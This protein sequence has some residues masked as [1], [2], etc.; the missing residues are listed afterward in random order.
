MSTPPPARRRKDAREKAAA[1]ERAATD[2]VLKHGY[3]AVKVD[4]ICERA[5]VSQRT[6]FNHFGTKDAALLGREYP[7]L[8]EIL[9]EEFVASTGPLMAGAARL[10]RV[11]PGDLGAD[12]AFLARRIRAIGSSPTLMALQMDRIESLDAAL[13]QVIHRR[14]TAQYPEEDAAEL[15]AQAGLITQLVAGLMRYI[16]LSWA[17]EA[18]AGAIPSIDPESISA[19]LSRALAKLD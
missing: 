17:E 19:L 12:P 3:D 2:L 5:G 9:A 16:G 15:L 11:D 10:I 18:A 14:L 8:D 4:M 7:H 13:R 6:F 1:I